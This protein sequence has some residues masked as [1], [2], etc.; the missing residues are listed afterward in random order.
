MRFDMGITLFEP[1]MRHPTQ[2]L[3]RKVQRATQQHRQC[4]N[5]FLTLVRRRADHLPVDAGP[6]FR[7]FQQEF[8]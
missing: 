3:S 8:A 4:G 1:L 6:I 7:R 2:H 5:G